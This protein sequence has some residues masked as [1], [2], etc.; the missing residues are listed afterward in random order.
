MGGGGGGGGGGR[1]DLHLHKKNPY[2][3]DYIQACQEPAG[4]NFIARAITV[5]LRLN[6]VLE[7]INEWMNE[8]MFNGY[9]AQMNNTEYDKTNPNIYKRSRSEM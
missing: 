1:I 3:Y 9:P 6:P 2:A 8:L 7:T 4:E 5:C